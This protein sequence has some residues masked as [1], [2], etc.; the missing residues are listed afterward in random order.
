MGSLAR[1]RRRPGAKP[2]D[3]AFGFLVVMPTRNRRTDRDAQEPRRELIELTGLAGEGADPAPCD[4][5]GQILRP[6]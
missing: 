5:V 1:G 6:Q 4:A 2:S 3:S